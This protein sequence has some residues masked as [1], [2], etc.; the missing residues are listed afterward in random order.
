MEGLQSWRFAAQ[1]RAELNNSEDEVFASRWLEIG[2]D[3]RWAV[4]PQWTFVAGAT[5]RQTRHPAQSTTQDAW[6]D[7][8][9]AFRLE[10]TRLLWEHVQLFVRY[11]HE[12]NQSPIAENDYDRD[13]VAASIEFWR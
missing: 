12:N 5:L 3:A 1:A 2:A 6:D 4:S 10:A 9:T 7:D 13:W 11:E 8:R